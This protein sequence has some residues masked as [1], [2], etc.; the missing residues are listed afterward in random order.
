MI[1]T[2][3]YHAQVIH[4]IVMP[5]LSILLSPSPFCSRY[6]AARNT[7]P[8]CSYRWTNDLSSQVVV[9]D[10]SDDSYHSCIYVAVK[11]DRELFMMRIRDNN[12]QSDFL[13]RILPTWIGLLVC[14]LPKLPDYIPLGEL[15]KHCGPCGLVVGTF[16][17]EIFANI[18]LR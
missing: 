16:C 4:N 7:C 13:P 17:Q 11:C 18:L 6:W 15:Y 12:V 1:H 10:D 9:G 5:R 2:A 14:W 8:K 3:V